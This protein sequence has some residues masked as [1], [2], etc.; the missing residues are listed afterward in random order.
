[1]RVV[2]FIALLLVGT[3]FAG[4]VLAAEPARIIVVKS[5]DLSAYAGVVAGFRAVVKGAVAEVTLSEDVESAEKAFAS[6]RSVKPD[7]VFAVGPLAAN[8]ARRT[9]T[10][11]PVVFAMVPY[12]ERYGLE[13]PNV[14]GISLTTDFGTELSTLKSVSPNVKRIGILHDPRY[15]GDTLSEAKA[16]AQKQGL[17]IVPLEVDS[18]SRVDRVLTASRARVDGFLMIADKTVANAG[19]VKQLIRF[20]EAE[21]VPLV[22]LSPSQVKEGALLSLSPLPLGIGQQAGRIANRVVHERIAIGAV[23]VASPEVLELAVNLTTAGRLGATP[24]TS[25]DLS[26]AVLRYAAQKG[27]ALKVYE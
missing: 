27:L 6:I 25:S 17:S 20:A 24:K 23:A 21:R 13:S 16:A 15:S 1:M 9:L 7:L 3:L 19:V 2:P 8:A 18:A 11:I 22:G 10:D 5:A 14:T 4:P 26:L 12:F